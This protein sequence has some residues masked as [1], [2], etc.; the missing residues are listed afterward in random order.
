LLFF[1]S[2]LLGGRREI[3]VTD[4]LVIVIIILYKYSYLKVIIAKTEH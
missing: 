2:F 1:F 3:K 4:E